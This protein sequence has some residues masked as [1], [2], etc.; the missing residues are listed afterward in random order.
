MAAKVP[1]EVKVPT[2]NSWMTTSSQGRPPVLVLPHERSGIDHL[3]CAVHVVG[4][5]S[6]GGVGHLLP[7][8]DAETVACAG[9]GFGGEG[10]GTVLFAGH[11][12]RV[13]FE[14]EIH[15]CGGGRP[16]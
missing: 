5:A 10:E 15:R 14:D 9:R 3:A 4:L 12:Y 7:A 6:G 2:C 13:L 1:S 8:V 11:R 16:Q